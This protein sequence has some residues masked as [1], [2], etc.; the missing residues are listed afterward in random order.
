ME[1]FLKLSDSNRKK[2]HVPL[3]RLNRAL[4]ENDHSDKAL[5][6]GIALEA[7]VGDDDQ[8]DLSYKVRQ[9]GTFFL[10]GSPDDK[11]KNFN[12]L[13]KLYSLRSKV[14]HG[15]SMPSSF[16]L[17]GQQTST[18]KFLRECC[19]I[20]ARLIRKWIHQFF[21]CLPSQLEFGFCASSGISIS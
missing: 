2:L 10:G 17:N 16:T 15:K 14:A 3:S 21:T 6:L 7:L 8:V 18:D 1:G 4:R 9:R 13:R 11:R 19:I 20:C 12:R 5:D